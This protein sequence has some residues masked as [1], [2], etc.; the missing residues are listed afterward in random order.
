[1]WRKGL[2]TNYSQADYDVWRRHFGQTAGSGSG[3]NATAAI[4][5][6]TT[7]VML[8]L[9]S[10]GVVCFRRSR[11]IEVPKTRWCVIRADKT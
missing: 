7:A 4:P 3:A 2:G 10:A 11:T 1:M 6:P 5:E 8:M 9:A